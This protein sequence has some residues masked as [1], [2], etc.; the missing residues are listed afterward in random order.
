MAS[1]M[2]VLSYSGKIGKFSCIVYGRQCSQHIQIVKKNAD[3]N[4]LID[5]TR[6]GTRLTITTNY[7]YV[8]VAIFRVHQYA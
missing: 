1:A 5:A 3:E 4:S 8:V 6:E 7:A 2:N